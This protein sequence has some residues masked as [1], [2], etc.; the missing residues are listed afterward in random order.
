VLG[1]P[2][3]IAWFE[4]LSARA[5]DLARMPRL[6]SEFV[7]WHKELLAAV[8][9]CFGSGSPESQTV[10]MLQFEVSP[11][12]IESLISV[13]ANPDELDEQQKNLG[14]PLDPKVKE[15]MIYISQRPGEWVEGIQQH[16]YEKMLA[17]ASEVLKELN[18]IL[19]NRDAHSGS[20]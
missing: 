10:R 18:V 8:E 6:S 16:F 2:K 7:E 12:T 17:R 14:R 11:G 1:P 9:N 15:G 20:S 5:A 19:R 4:K 13:F 3:C